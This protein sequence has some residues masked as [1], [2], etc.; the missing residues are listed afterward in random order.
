MSKLAN[1]LPIALIAATVGLV[2]TGHNGW[3]ITMFV[4]CVAAVL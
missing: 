4:F 2:I 1:T 3:A